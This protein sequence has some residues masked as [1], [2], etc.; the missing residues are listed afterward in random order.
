ME[1]DES[2]GSSCLF[3]HLLGDVLIELFPSYLS[4]AEPSHVVDH[5]SNVIVSQVVLQLL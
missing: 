5:F 4:L 1:Y 3:I 2:V